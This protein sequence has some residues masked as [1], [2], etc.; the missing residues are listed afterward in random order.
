MAKH[1]IDVSQWNGNIDFKKVKAAGVDFVIIR[2][3]YGRDVSQKDPYFE[4]NYKGA[5]AA[6]LNVG[7]YWYSYA[8]SDADAVKEAEACLKIIS[9][10]TFEY[11]IYFDVEEQAQFNRGRSFCD[12]ITKAFLNKLEAA[13]YFAGLYTGR[14]AAQ[15][16]FSTAV[17]DRYAFW[18]AEYGG[19]LNYTGNYGIWQNSSTWRVAGINGNVD[20]NY[21]YVDYPAI[22]KKGG[23]NGFKKQTVT[24]KTENKPAAKDKKKT[25]SKTKE[26]V[27]TVKTGD[28]L[29]GI[30]AKYNTTVAKLVKANN[31]KNPDLIYAG[32][33]IKIA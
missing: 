10:K 22:I 1:G 31:I 28:T 32:Q 29:S 7:A 19:K 21:S 23:F 13:G 9:G 3:G 11:P 6:G 15:N 33:K 8:V 24:S 17:R 25:E 4:Q 2:A 27:Y 20:H 26:V 30:A 12:G 18:I 5:K 16:Y 14:Y